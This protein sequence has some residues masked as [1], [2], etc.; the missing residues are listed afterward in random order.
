VPDENLMYLAGHYGAPPGELDQDI[1]DRAFSSGRG[2]QMLDW[3]PPQPSI[4]EIRRQYGAH[5]T[6]EELLLRFLI[7]GPD[8]DAMYAA[9]QPIEPILPVTGP[10]GLGWLA[11]VM[12]HT[13]GRSITAKRGAV[14]LTLKR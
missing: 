11:E 12:G 3:Q 4:E 13:S 9:A 7:P 5:V 2:R 1:V 8:V 10:H 6:D 14:T